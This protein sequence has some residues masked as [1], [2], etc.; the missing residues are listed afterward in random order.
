[1]LRKNRA[2]QFCVAITVLLVFLMLSGIGSANDITITIMWRAQMPEPEMLDKQI[3][4]FEKKNPGIKVEAIYVP[5]AE[6]EPKLLS[7]YAAGIAPDVLGVGG[8]NPYGE[9]WNRGMVVDI[10]PFLERDPDLVDGLYSSFLDIYNTD[11]HIIGLPIDTAYSGTF[12]NAT[13]FDEAGL[14]YPTTDWTSDD[15]TWDD[16]LMAAAKL[17]KDTDGDGKIDQFGAQ[18]QTDPYY[19]TRLWGGNLIREEDM[20]DR[21]VRKLGTDDPDTYNALIRSIEARADMIHKH[22]VTPNPAT[23][24]S[25]SQMGPPLKTG[26]VAMSVYDGSWAV[27]P[28]FPKEYKLG[29]A[30]V[31]KAVTRGGQ[32]WMG[33][34]QMTKTSKHQKEAWE[35]MKFIATDPE[36]IS[37]RID[38]WWS[39]PPLKADVPRYLERFTGDLVNST[40]SLKQVIDG[41]LEQ[42]DVLTD[43][44]HIFSN[45]AW[46][47][48]IF[49][50]ELEPVWLGTKDVKEAVDS[51]ISKADEMLQR[52]GEETGLF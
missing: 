12:Y 50:S 9:R 52:K 26:K 42:P 37:V 8:T 15:W 43:P 48:D 22:K 33:V 16:M 3:E 10:A 31:P 19:L 7:M 17:T 38:K 49:I 34:L 47:R 32:M 45:Y 28:P 46:L 36:A 20:G 29:S 24:A 41:C 6:Y 23:A 25:I 11:G 4:L 35:F 1:M 14:A 30:V 39:V 13:L 5:W 2:K 44:M 27:V 21:I 40:D 51:L 18:G